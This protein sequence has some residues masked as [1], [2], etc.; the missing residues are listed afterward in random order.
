MCDETCRW[1]GSFSI[2]KECKDIDYGIIGRCGKLSTCKDDTFNYMC[3]CDEGCK[4][5]DDKESYEICVDI[6]VRHHGGRRRLRA[7]GQLRGR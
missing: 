5:A 1:D 4:V 3:E 6:D 2:T 7:F